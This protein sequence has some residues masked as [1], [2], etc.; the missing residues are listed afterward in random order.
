MQVITVSSFNGGQG[1]ST[2]ALMVGKILAEQYRV[3]LVDCEPQSSL[4]SWVLGAY[5]DP[6]YMSLREVLEGNAPAADALFRLNEN[7]ALLP[8][9]SSLI[10]ANESLA[11]GGRGFFILKSRLK[12][13]ADQFDF[14]IVDT[15]PEP[16][17][18]AFTALG[19][20]DGVVIPATADLKGVQALSRT[21]SILAE[22]EQD[23]GVGIPV[24]AVAPFKVS[25]YG[26][27]MFPECAQAVER[28][29]EIAGQAGA[30]VAPK[31]LRSDQFDRAISQQKTLAEIG[32]PHL[33]QPF[34]AIAEQIVGKEAQA[35][36]TAVA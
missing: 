32:K 28:M 12:P 11:S 34:Q 19:A 17:Q 33:E 8:S 16:I 3:L 2:T 14:A 29:E 25:M 27:N 21:V 6:S 1:K 36:R 24:L 35:W 26:R 10:K 23:L 5:L 18:L 13:L 31:V 30:W 9:D 7:L 22:I 15:P 4:T 20:A